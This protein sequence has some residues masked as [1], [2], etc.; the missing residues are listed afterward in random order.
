MS[1]RV[2]MVLAALV[3]ALIAC[4]WIWNDGL[5]D[6]FLLRKFTD[7]IEYLSFWR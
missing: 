5:A 1:D 2:A 3:L 7:F 4:D 6:M